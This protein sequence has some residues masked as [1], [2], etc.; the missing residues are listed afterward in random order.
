[1]KIFLTGASGYIGGSVAAA[2]TASGHRV[3]GLVR[4]PEKADTVRA[5]GIE[6]VLGNLADT[7]LLARQAGAA[8]AVVNTAS[9]DDRGAVEAMLPALKNSRR[10]FVHTSGSS[11]VGDL[12]AGEAGDAVYDEDTPFEPQPGRATRVA[13]DHAVLAAAD[14]GV[15]AVVIC[16]SLIYGRGS[17]ANPDSIQIPWLIAL[18]KKHGV[19]RHVGRGENR[20]SNV[21][22][23]DLVDLYLLAIEKAP[24][25]AFYYAENGENSM[26]E[27]AEAI[28][29]MLG[30]G[31]RTEPWPLQEAIAEWGQS[32]AQ[33]TFGS[34]SRVR[35]VRARRELG[36]SPAARSLIE[37][38]ERGVY[39]ETAC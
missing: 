25:G 34:N 22:I 29:G 5:L 39:A 27:A 3:T 15:R 2:L 30:F 4:S 28:S 37:E 8:D 33:Y 23:D 13:N 16:P 12:A 9:A 17:G 20:W 24:A 21:H 19:G 11:I 14:D 10:L 1:M 7:E 35:A 32:A 31:G 6:P 36:W 18:A 26:R 38:I